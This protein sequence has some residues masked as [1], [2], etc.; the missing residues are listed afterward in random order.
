[1]T[2]AVKSTPI[3]WLHVLS[4]IAPPH[5]RRENAA[6]KMWKKCT[7]H[8]HL[9]EIP[10]RFDLL[11]PPP[12]RLASRKPIWKDVNIQQ[13]NYS[14]EEEWRKYWSDQPVFSN[15][16]IIADPTQRVAG[17]SLPRKD[18]KTLNRF[19]TGHGCCAEQMLRWNFT[20]SSVCDCDSVTTQSMEHLINN[21]TLRKFDGGIESLHR[22]TDEAMEWVKNFDLNV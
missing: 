7:E 6:H 14:I 1:M 17:F 5:L 16:A 20:S 18:W 12:D 22:L 9:A 3:P 4:N 15:K 19:R 11:N 10:L 13:H 8:S 2:G 21:C